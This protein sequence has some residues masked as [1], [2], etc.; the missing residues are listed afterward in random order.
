MQLVKQSLVS[1][2]TSQSQVIKLDVV[3][4]SAREQQ[5]QKE[6][7]TSSCCIAAAVKTIS[8]SQYCSWV[9]LKEQILRLQRDEY[10]SAVCF[11]GHST[12]EP[13]TEMT[14]GNNLAFRHQCS[15]LGSEQQTDSNVLRGW[16]CVCV[17][18]TLTNPRYR[19][20]LVCEH[21]FFKLE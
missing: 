20:P 13:Q 14:S 12:D 11:L 15:V 18:K 6:S 5:G 21:F 7:H 2:S 1:L 17:C 16:V 10:A 9:T 19:N 4:A 3:F 8:E